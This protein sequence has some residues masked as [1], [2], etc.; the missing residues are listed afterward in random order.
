MV[1]PGNKGRKIVLLA[2]EALEAN[3]NPS[4]VVSPLHYVL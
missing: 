4:D 2:A 3:K 1:L